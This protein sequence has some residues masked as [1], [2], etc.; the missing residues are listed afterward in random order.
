MRRISARVLAYGAIGA[1]MAMPRFFVISEATNP[2]RFTFRSRCS[3]EKVSSLERLWRTMSPSSRVTGR[4][5][6]SR[7]F[8]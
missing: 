7:N 3:L 4:S 5:P 1:Q 2:M 6:R 8:E